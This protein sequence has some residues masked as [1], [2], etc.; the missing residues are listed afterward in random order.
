HRRCALFPYTALFRSAGK[1]RHSVEAMISEGAKRRRYYEELVTSSSVAR[2]VAAGDGDEAATA[3]LEQH[4][5]GGQSVGVVWL[6]G[7]GPR[8]EEHT[9]ELQ[10]RENL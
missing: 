7:A 8:S 1:M 9:S 5:N 6:I 2:A 10:S 4:A 3:L